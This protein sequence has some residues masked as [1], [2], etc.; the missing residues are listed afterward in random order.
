MEQALAPSPWQGHAHAG[1]SS[2]PTAVHGILSSRGMPSFSPMQMWSLSELGCAWELM[3]AWAWELMLAMGMGADAAHGHG[4]DAGADAGANACH[5]HRANAAMEQASGPCSCKAM[6]HAGMSSIPT[7]AHGIMSSRHMPSTS[8][9]PIW[10]LSE[11]A[12][13]WEVMLA[14]VM[15]ADA[16]YGDGSWCWAWAWR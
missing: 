11:L 15:G 12:W 9:M 14:M 16:D 1:M 2:I 6:P 4:A 13:A 7:A 3:L 10:N 8:S 5:G